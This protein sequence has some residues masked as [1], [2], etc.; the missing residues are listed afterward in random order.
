MTTEN[1][2]RDMD[3]IRSALGEQEISYYG[4]SY[5][6]YM[7]A[8]YLS[9]FPRRGERFALDSV[10][11][12]RAIWRDTYRR[13]GRAVEVRFPDFTR[14]AAE[15]NEVYGLGTTDGEVRATYFNLA[16]RLDTAPVTLPDGQVIDGNL[17]RATT[18]VALYSDTMFPGLAELW[19][20]LDDAG[21][22]APATQAAAPEPSFPT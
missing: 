21:A 16:S 15:R 17:F 12:P 8:V 14:F 18:Y 5:A 13:M 10:V 1:R 11:S 3:R 9:L 4:Y 6:T 19:R 2:A 22:P 20:L 7:G